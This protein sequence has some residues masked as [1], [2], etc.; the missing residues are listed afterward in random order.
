MCFLMPTKISSIDNFVGRAS[1]IGL[2]RELTS[3]SLCQWT[4]IMIKME[5]PIV[6][7]A[8]VST[9]ELSMCQKM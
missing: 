9:L 6:P 3:P 7:S 5:T 1:L 8:S 2:W 4:W